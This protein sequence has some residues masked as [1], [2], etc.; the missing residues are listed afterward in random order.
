LE[1][2]A[3]TPILVLAHDLDIRV[4][5]ADGELIRELILDPT[6]DYQPQHKT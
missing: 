2:Y 6:R 3:G 1:R 4:L 5:T